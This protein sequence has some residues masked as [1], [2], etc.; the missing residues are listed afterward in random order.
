MDPAIPL[1]LTLQLA[2]YGQTR[3]IARNCPTPT[4]D[5]FEANPLL[6]KHPSVGKVGWYFIGETASIFAIRS[7]LPATWGKRYEWFVVAYSSATVA[8]NAH[9][10]VRFNF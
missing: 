10:G 1:I 2:D 6:G 8:R 9:I 3:W 7:A 5:C 4:L